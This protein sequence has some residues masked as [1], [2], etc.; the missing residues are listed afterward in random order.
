MS[1]DICHLGANHQISTYVVFSPVRISGFDGL[2]QLVSACAIAMIAKCCLNPSCYDHIYKISFVLCLTSNNK[3]FIELWYPWSKLLEILL[4]EYSSQISKWLEKYFWS[5]CADKLG[6][7]GA[8]L[9]KAYDVTIQR[10]RNSYAKIQDSKMHILRC[11]G[12]KFC[13]K[14]QRCPLK[15]HTKFWT[16]TPQNV[17]FTRW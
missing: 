17:H 15:F 13:V 7:T 11:M 1:Y 12:S 4:K 14:F 2:W 9:T 5:H 10:Y 8:R 3:I 16:H 6:Q